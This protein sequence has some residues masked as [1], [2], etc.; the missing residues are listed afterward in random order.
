MTLADTLT[1]YIESLLKDMLI[2]SA[3]PIHTNVVK[4][5]RTTGLSSD[6]DFQLEQEIEEKFAEYIAGNPDVI[7][8]ATKASEST[9]S[10]P[11]NIE[12]MGTGNLQKGITGVQN[13]TSI[14]SQGLALLPHAVLISLAVSLAPF[15]FTIFTKPGGPLDLRFKRIIENEINGFLA[16][17]TQID[18]EMGVR[19]VIIQSKTGFTA[20]NGA[21]NYNTVRGIREGGINEELLE[22]VGKVDHTKGDWPFG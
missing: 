13:P 17:Q 6:F 11:P 19:Q 9:I 14:V 3:N 8:D 7:K 20:T 22:R 4:E 15:I 5:I 16:R 12:K 18:T 21:N 2:T 1:A 10:K